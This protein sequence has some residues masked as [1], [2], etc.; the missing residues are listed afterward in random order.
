MGL[1]GGGGGVFFPGGCA[2]MCDEGVG[3]RGDGLSPFTKVSDP[4]GARPEMT[5]VFSSLS[6]S[7]IK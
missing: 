5:R 3:C 2:C 1:G 7:A 6:Y 4:R